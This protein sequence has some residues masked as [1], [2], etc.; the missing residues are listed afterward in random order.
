MKEKTVFLEAKDLAVG[1]QGSRV[2]EGISICLHSGEILALAGPN[3][4]G[5]STVLKTLVRQL[6]I[7]CGE[8]RIREL[9]IERIRDAEFAKEAAIVFPGRLQTER[10]SCREIV[11]MGRYPYTG[12]MG[13]LREKDKRAVEEAILLTG[14]GEIADCD[15]QKVSDGQRQRVLLARAI[16]QEPD[17]LVLDEPTTYLDIRHKRELL[18]LIR[19]LAKERGMAAVLSLHEPDL[20][21]KAADTVLCVSDGHVMYYGD[22]AAFSQGE[23]VG[24]LYGLE[25]D[26]YAA[27][28]GSFELEKPQGRPQVFVIA[29]GGSGT[30]AYRLLQKRGIPFCTGIFSEGDLDAPAAKALARTVVWEKPFEPVSEEAYRRAFDL[31]AGCS[32]VINCVDAWGSMNERCRKLFEEAKR[33]GLEN[34]KM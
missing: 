25:Q 18:D 27:A 33:L 21:E 7:V 8:A 6:K 31:L 17:I 26:S 22:A 16:C 12:R 29:G 3:G 19:R 20:V 13:F 5:K 28:F 4:C 32:A 30:G 2:A 15:F 10:M 34:W 23:L 1:Y 24:R 9:P 14:I 11:G